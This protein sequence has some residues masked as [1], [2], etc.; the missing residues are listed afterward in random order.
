MTFL[1]WCVNLVSQSTAGVCCT[2]ESDWVRQQLPALVSCFVVFTWTTACLMFCRWFNVVHWVESDAVTGAVFWQQGLDVWWSA[3]CDWSPRWRHEGKCTHSTHGRQD[4]SVTSRPTQR[5]LA[6]SSHTCPCSWG[7]LVGEL[8]QH[9]TPL[10]YR[11]ICFWHVILIYDPKWN[12]NTYTIRSTLRPNKDCRKCPFVRA[13]VRPCVR[14]STKFLR[15]QWNLKFDMRVEVDEWCMTVCSMTRSK[16]RS[17]AL[18]GWKSSCFQKLSPPPLRM[19][20]GNWPRILKL[21]HN[22]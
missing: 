17:R 15:F 5:L 21:G 18:Q 1:R 3:S 12:I 8:K 11:P 13:Y 4:V 20:A 19:G 9:C 6:E 10:N 7:Q 22:I 14:L 2:H 16:S